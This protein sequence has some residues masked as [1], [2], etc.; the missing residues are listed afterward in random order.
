MGGRK[1]GSRAR[2][3]ALALFSFFCLFH[4][5]ALAGGKPFSGGPEEAHSAWH[6][7]CGSRSDSLGQADC[8][9]AMGKKGK[10]AWTDV[11]FHVQVKPF[12]PRKKTNRKARKGNFLSHTFGGTRTGRSNAVSITAS[13]W[14]LLIR[15]KEAWGSEEWERLCSV[16]TGKTP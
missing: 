4:L 11:L 13:C 1:P 6:G 5:R 12:Y 14:S 10:R 8:P 16:S 15:G 7:F 2:F 3:V 9:P